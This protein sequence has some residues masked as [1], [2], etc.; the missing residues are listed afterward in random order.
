MSIG[1][2]T[3]GIGWYS[4]LIIP[5][6]TLSGC[7]YQEEYGCVPTVIHVN[8]PDGSSMRYM[9]LGG[10]AEGYRYMSN[11]ASG[12][13]L[14]ATYDYLFVLKREKY[15]RTYLDGGGI[16]SVTDLLG[17]RLTYSTLAWS[18]STIYRVT[19]HVGQYVEFA[20]PGVANYSSPSTVR[21][22]A[23]GI[24]QY[25]YNASGMLETVTSPGSSPDIRRYHYESSAGTNLLT[26]V[27]I[28]NVRYSTYS[29][30][31]DK[32]V[33]V[34]G[35]G[36]AVDR[37]TFAYGAGST[38]LTNA[39][40]HA[41]TY[42]FSDVSGVKYLASVAR[43]STTTCGA[44]SSSITYTANQSINYK[45]DWN[46]NKTQY[47]Y[48]GYMRVG[49][50]TS[51]VGT[52]AQKTQVNSW[53]GWDDFTLLETTLKN[54]AGAAYLKTTYTYVASGPAT[55]S[56]ASETVSDLRTGGQRQSLYNYTFH[57]NNAIATET[58]TRVLPGGNAVTTLSYD[59]LGNRVSL[60]NALGHQ[61]AWTNFNGYGQAG[62]TTDANGVITDFAYDGTGNLTSRTQ[63]LPSGPRTT[64]FAFNNSRQVTDIS[65]ADGRVQRTRYSAANRL[66]RV[67]NAL[68]EYMQRGFDVP[69]NTASTSSA[70][71][72][73][74]MSGST[75]VASA[76]GSF[77]SSTPMDGLRRPWKEQGSGGQQVIYTY[78]GNGNVKSRSDAGGRVTSH[79]YDSQN[80]RTSTTAPDGGITTYVYDGE[81]NLASVTDPRGI[82]TSYAYNGLG[83]VTQR[84]SRDTGTTT[85]S[86]DSAGRLATEQ[87]ANGVTVAYAW[88]A[89]DRM[90]SRTASGVSETF[91]YDEGSYGKGRL[92]RLNDATGQTT[93]TYTADGQLAQQVSTIYGASHTTTWAYNSAGQLTGMSYPNGLALSYSYD[94]YGRLAHLGSNLGGTW[95]TL[96]NSFL[97]QPA[98]DQRFAWRFAN[99]M[100]RT[101]THDTDRR[102]TNLAGAS[103][104]GL[105]YGWNNTDT[106][107]S[108]TDNV[109]ASLNAGFGYDANDR[110]TSVSRSGDAQGFG[111]DLVGNRSS[112]SRAGASYTLGLDSASN[113][114]VSVSG[115]ASR[116]FGYD[117]LGNLASDSGSLGNRTFGYDAF[118]RLGA[119][120]LG[121][122]LSGDYRSNAL[123]Q[124][125][126][127]GWPGGSARF[128]YGPGGE[129]LAED[130]P[131][132]TN[133]VW[134]GGELL[135]IVRGGT[136]Y[137]SHNDH[138]GR[139]EVMSNAAGAVV[140]RASNAA[141]DR[142]V[143]VD[144]IGGMNVG[145]PGQYLDAES[146]LYYNWHR[147]YDASVGR[148]TQSDPIG[149]A[150][151]INT[152]AYVG[153][154][155]ISRVDPMG[156][157]SFEFGG[158]AGVGFTATFGQN[159][160]GSGF[161][162]LKVGFGLG[163]G[164]S[165]DPLGKQ[166]GYMPCQ[167]SSWTGG[168]GLFA[169]AGVHAGIAQLGGSHD[170][171][172]TK[173]S[174][175]TNSFVDPG[176]KN[177]FSGIG[178]KGIAAGGIKASIGGGGSATG[179]CTC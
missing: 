12:G 163:S 64:T 136:F 70:R 67:G 58:V 56:L 118:N 30:Y 145:L 8:E 53:Q 72:V 99:G 87:R 82:P 138:L 59:T 83:Q 39:A 18:P 167:C 103:V 17:H 85:F 108:L 75:P 45:L 116:S 172:K 156:L 159:P 151:G 61:T 2:T 154:N 19:N 126:W 41:T 86:Y 80:R 130:G 60:T 42:T 21:D 125:A 76:S 166:A 38:T 37:D 158:F 46:G 121:G 81:G 93:Y 11:N 139:P 170:V 122:V 25:T 13:L 133:Y 66:D 55:G 40:G 146:G 157:W 92:T 169:E 102:L 89:L 137:A 134:L 68:G 36:D 162:S 113:R 119:F 150:G 34:S 10:A 179:G 177:E 100:A 69:S 49:E 29:Y 123:N 63:Y 73:P 124:R 160:N 78:D 178:M 106:I 16:L 107:A 115:S 147:Y 129:L 171:G 149:L 88:D 47:A 114:L 96:A 50:I 120:Y 22:P 90:T 91:T 6:L 98:T 4:S 175:G 20:F 104:H 148:Y 9:L 176:V 141:F 31:S 51:A 142:S 132:Q 52:P 14:V 32:R 1:L 95:A 111:L 105:S 144:T 135:G 84:V 5:G 44:T 23:G 94:V 3:F 65:T 127:K 128:V 28:N 74:T 35:L 173:N 112:H 168:L 153:G 101:Y 110:L 79:I 43:A 164:W 77:T 152:Y 165:F 174:C 161:A 140:W 24:W 33:Q 131:A 48:D 117:A 54:A 109:Y 71:N 27:S 62:R 143:A 26:G 155:P 15:T 57:P 97:Y 7:Y